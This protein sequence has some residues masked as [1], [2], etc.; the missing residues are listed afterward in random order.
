MPVSATRRQGVNSSAA[1]KVPCIAATTAN[2]TL[3]G[4]Q[5]INA[6]A[7]VADDRVLVKDQ[8]DGIENGI[9]DVSTGSWTRAPDWDGSWDVVSGTS[10]YVTGGTNKTEWYV[11]TSGA[12]VVGTTSIA[13]AIRAVSSATI[14]QTFYPADFVV[15]A[16]NGAELNLGAQASTNPQ[17]DSLI[18]DDT[19]QESADLQFSVLNYGSGNLTLDIF[20]NAATATS[21]DVIFGAIVASITPETDTTNIE[22][23]TFDAE[24]TV[25]DTHLGTTAKRLHKT[26]MTISNTDSMVLDDEVWL[27]FYR[28]AGSDDLSGDVSVTKVIVSYSSA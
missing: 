5:T 19:T 18:F 10:V 23:K 3:S 11:T 28:K 4:E 2:I 8:T 14:S 1:H 22:T 21:G 13:F 27:N 17:I 6:I 9:Y 25:T 7:V 15:R 20:W 12:V 26:S 24:N 16:S